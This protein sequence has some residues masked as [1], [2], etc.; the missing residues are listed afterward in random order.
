M[1]NQI[2]VVIAY[3]ETTG[4]SN[5]F[6]R[7]DDK[8]TLNPEFWPEGISW[9]SLSPLC[10]ISLSKTTN[11]LMKEIGVHTSKHSLSGN[12]KM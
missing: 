2:V 3:K 12:K 1:T 11:K 6:K 8:L 7:Q 5:L 4:N 10:T 9:N